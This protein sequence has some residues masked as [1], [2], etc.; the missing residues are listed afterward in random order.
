MEAGADNR[1]IVVAAFAA[2]AL[3]LAFGAIDS[4]G[5]SWG[6][7]HLG[8][9][10][11]VWPILLLVLAAVLWIPRIA[12]RLAQGAD[13][14]G[15]SL[16]RRPWGL[17]AALALA[18]LALFAAFPIA[19][20]LYGDT[21]YYINDYSSEYLGVHFERMLRLGFQSRGAAT[22]VLHDLV[23]RATGLGFERAYILV[24][25]LCGGIFVFA[26]ARFAATLPGVAP[27]ARAAILLLGIFDG[28]NQLFFGHIE[29]YTVVRLFMCLF[30]MDL[31][32][33]WAAANGPRL[34]VRPLIWLGLAIFFHI[35][36]AAL[37]PSLLLW[38]GTVAAAK[39]E[40]LRRWFPRRAAILG[41]AIGIVM[42]AALYAGVGSYCYDYIYS[43]G[44]PVPQQLFLPITTSCV[45]LP[46]LRYTLFS[47]PHFLDLVGSL[48]SVSSP[49]ILLVLAVCWRQGRAG[50]GGW[51]LLPSILFALV[52][53]FI[54]NPAIGFPYDW[55]LMCLLSP[56]LLYG[57][58]YAVAR[59]PRAPGRIFSTLV[60]LSLA[61]ATIFAV[62][63]DASRVRERIEDMGIWL[64]RTYYGGS[65]YRLSANSSTIPDAAAQREDR[66]RVLGRLEHQVYPDDREVAFLWERLAM[67]RIEAE[68][69]TGALEAYRRAL[70]V[71][72]SRWDR[73]KPVG[74]LETEVGSRR[75]GIELLRQYLSEAPR[76]GEAYLFLGDALAR[77][78]FQADARRVWLAFLELS[79]D[80]PDA[81]RVRRDLQRIAP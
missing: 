19:T 45:G 31:V 18:A 8:R 6:W 52:H 53:N 66:L 79:P 73:K 15:E 55:D 76:D 58:S 71:E 81:E 39:R 48:G 47:A 21:L 7:D 78:G 64:H 36:A 24:S 22:F 2:L 29:N 32:R 59:A 27:W 9:V 77:E 57:A 16:Q 37:V 3:P 49:A 1:R 46:P 28:A 65:H 72:P 10:G 40:S 50:A 38:I 51:I 17:P 33:A 62:N 35:Q 63:S 14:L 20:R 69:Y 74:Y 13:A 75:R 67:M 11:P 61:T 23:G 26:H 25:T 12:G 56:P 5:W 43:G 34:R 44:R 30:L 41:S 60:P 54:L 68:D 42:V 4:T 70:G 80:S